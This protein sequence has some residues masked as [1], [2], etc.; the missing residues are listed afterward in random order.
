MPKL[1]LA[2]VTGLTFLCACSHSHTYTTKDASVTIDSKGKDE[3]VVH[4]T[5]KDGASLDFN[6]GKPI[7][8]YPSDTPLYQGKTVMDMK[9]EKDH[10]RH[11]TLQTSDSMDKILDFYKIAIGKQR[12]E[13]RIHH[14]DG[15]DEHVGGNQRRT[16]VSDF[17][18]HRRQNANHHSAGGR[19][20][21]EY[22]KDSHEPAK[23]RILFSSLLRTHRVRTQGRV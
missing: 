4:V 17:H 3:A 11:I 9:S 16:Q 18:Q 23:V 21:S 5:G 15:A 10:V 6:T 14:G 22:S 19:P 8:D 12:L 1:H 20:L 2:A 7:T 13:D